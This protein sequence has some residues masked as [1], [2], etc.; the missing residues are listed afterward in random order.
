MKKLILLC[1][2][3]MMT[4]STMN[5]KEQLDMKSISNGDFYGERLAAVKPASDGE[6]YMQISPDKRKI[7]K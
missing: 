3:A 5:A 2:L 4:L 7:G 6:T 1:A